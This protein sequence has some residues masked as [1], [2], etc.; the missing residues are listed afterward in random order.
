[1][2]A[3]EAVP[4]TMQAMVI[5]A[6]G[7]PE[8][9]V[10]R[11]VP[12][13]QIGDDEVL[14]R[15]DTAGVGVWDAK[16][17]SGA[18]ADGHEHFPMILGAEGSGTIAELGNAVQ[19]LSLGDAVYGYAYGDTKGGFYAE[20]VALAAAHVA[21]IPASLDFREAGAVPVTGLTALAGIDDALALRPGQTVLIHGASGGVGTLA[22]QFAKHRGARVLA[23]AKGRDA[24]EF[25]RGLHVDE[26]IDTE[27]DDVLAAARRF[28]PGGVDALLALAGG[29][30]LERAIAALRDGATIAHPN[31]VDVPNLGAIAFDGVPNPAA[32]A[33]LS[34]TIDAGPIDVPVAATYGLVSADEAHRRLER[35]HV[36]G[37]I[38]L[39]VDATE[40]VV[41]KVA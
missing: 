13:P 33:R 18:W 16:A 9:L 20:Y 8:R 17:R 24:R 25:L 30:E 5:D 12:V 21:P 28:A 32:F 27:H 36:L 34:A 29:P 31:G 11:E 19:G 22:V 37:K 7:G 35:G 26:A 40:D 14:V 2:R 23:T 41:E 4:A 6:F 10:V 15:V 38:I 39:V 3:D 1:M